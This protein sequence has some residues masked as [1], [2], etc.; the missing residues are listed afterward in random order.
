MSFVTP[1]YA[2]CPICIVTVG[3]GMYLAK[4][5]GVDDLLVS[6]WISALNTAI[7]FWLAPKLKI[8]LLKNPWILSLIMLGLT[9]FYFQF[10]DQIGSAANRLLGIDKIIF[11]QSLGLLVMFFANWLYAFTKKKNNDKTV[12]PYAKVAFPFLSVLIFTLIFK[13]A[14]KL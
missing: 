5:L 14:F 3:G 9:L 8:K 12:F 1:A 13:F 10:T 11:G 6:I 7:S 2:Q 4:K